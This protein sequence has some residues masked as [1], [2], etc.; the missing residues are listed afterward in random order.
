MT[1][2]NA[3]FPDAIPLDHS[4]DRNEAR[5]LNPAMA[6]PLPPLHS[7]QNRWPQFWQTTVYLRVRFPH[8]QHFNWVTFSLRGIQ[9]FFETD[10]P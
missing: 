7:L 10:N 9:L 8:L 1:T 6:H 4:T 5:E 3:P 2:H